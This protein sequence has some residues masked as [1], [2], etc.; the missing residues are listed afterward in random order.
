MAEVIIVKVIDDL[1]PYKNAA[2]DVRRY[3]G[4]DGVWYEIDLA[5]SNS[6]SLTDVLE[7]YTEAG[8]PMPED[9]VPPRAK[10]ALK[11]D[12]YGMTSREWN[13]AMRDWAEKEGRKDEIT[14]KHNGAFYYPR[15]LKDDFA[16]YMRQLH[17]G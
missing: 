10:N 9:F 16:A 7:R 8:R 5:L 11:D 17:A 4:L 13:S 3:F 12:H 6:D 2:A 1:D 15:R 14:G